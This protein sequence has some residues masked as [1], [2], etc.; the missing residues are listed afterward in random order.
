MVL[1]ADTEHM[2]SNEVAREKKAYSKLCGIQEET[3]GESIK[4]DEQ[5]CRSI[6]SFIRGLSEFPL[7]EGQCE[8][9]CAC[10]DQPRDCKAIQYGELRISLGMRDS[11]SSIFRPTISSR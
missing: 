10:P 3:D 6:A 5:N 9:T 4:H 2:M 8:K 11:P 1:E 7:K